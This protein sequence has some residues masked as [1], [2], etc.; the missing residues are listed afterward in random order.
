MPPTSRCS[1]RS[2]SASG[3]RCDDATNFQRNYSIGEV[4]VEDG[5]SSTTRPSTGSAGTTSHTSP[6]L[7]RPP[8]S[9]RSA[10]RFSGPIAAGTARSS[11]RRAGRATRSPTAGRRAART[12]SSSTLEPGETRDVVFVLGYAEN[13]RRREVRP[14]RLADDRQ[15][16]AS[17]PVIARYLDP[18]QVEARSTRLRDH[19][20]GLLGV[21]QVE[22]PSEHANRMVNVWNP[23]QCMV[24]FNLS[25]SASLFE[26]G[27]G[28]G[29][30]FRDSNQDLLG[31]VHLVPERARARILDIAATQL[32]TGGAYHQYQPLT[33][34][35]NDAVGCGF[36]DDPLWLILAV[37]GLP[38]GDRRPVRSCE[39]PVPYD[40]AAGHGDAALRAPAACPPLHAR[41]AR[42][43]RVAADRA[44]RLERLP[45]P[46]LLLGGA[47]R[48]VPDDRQP[49]GRRRR[50]GVHRRAV[51]ARSRGACRDRRSARRRRRGGRLPRRR[52][53]TWRRRSWSTVGTASGSDAPTTTRA[54]RSVRSENDEGQIFI[55]PQGMC[56]MAGIGLEDGRGRTRLEIR[57]RA[58]RHAPRHRAASSPP[59]RATT[60][61]SARS[62]PTRRVTR[63]TAASSATPTRG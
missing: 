40:N 1:A 36:N 57:A 19:W 8:V 44:C 10:R 12:T 34:R 22:T 4:E 62:R 2:S 60:W 9:T 17:R 33:K 37:A 5:T 7:G 28:R 39:E 11:S 21:L 35:G 32:P 16:A 38:E 14:A 30:G 49:R 24:T 51:R 45:E 26:S 18:A 43:A 56:V 54:P 25:R 31:F 3:T 41:P 52:R 47:R 20:D 63:R 15:A 13:P 6:A 23:Y 48:V 42:P 58:P 27:I 46:E 50:V 59:I 53:S 61:S 29:M 55:E